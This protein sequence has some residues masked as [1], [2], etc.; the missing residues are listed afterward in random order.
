MRLWSIHPRYLDAKGLVA[1]WREGLLAQDVLSGHT[2]GY[3]EHPQLERFKDTSDPVGA[4]AS[5]LRAIIDDADKRGYN[6]NRSKI[7]HKNIQ[8]RM[9][10]TTGQVE[11]EFQ[12][13]LKKLKER[14]PDLYKQL[15]PITE[16]EV[17][18]VF[19]KVY[20][21]VENWEKI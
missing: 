10:V 11:Y 14:D 5:Y 3:K 21:D 9:P 19:T 4:I 12:H 13:L 15:S 17:N 20:G 18:P 7:V 1:L 8:R 2:K 6:F 16:I